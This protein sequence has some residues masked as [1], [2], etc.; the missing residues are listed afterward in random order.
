ME[1]YQLLPLTGGGGGGAGGAGTA[2]TQRNTGGPGG[3]G[4]DFSPY[5]TLPNVQYLQVVV[6]E[7]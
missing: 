6:V 3:A 4:T 5:R 7:Q 2:G 1:R